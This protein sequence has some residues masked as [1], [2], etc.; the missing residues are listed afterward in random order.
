M[1]ILAIFLATILLISIGAQNY[2]QLYS[3]AESSET[4]QNNLSIAAETDKQKYTTNDKTIEIRG[5]IYSTLKN[6][7]L[8]VTVSDK[9]DSVIFFDENIITNDDVFFQQNLIP[10][11]QN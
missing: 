3:S 8:I 1:R 7:H 5:K 10:R 4:N 11:I 2:T 9:N 6:L